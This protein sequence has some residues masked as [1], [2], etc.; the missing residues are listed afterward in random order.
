VHC[1]CGEYD[2]T[3]LTGQASEASAVERLWLMRSLATEDTASPA[4][5]VSLTRRHI[6]I[7]NNDIFSANAVFCVG[8]YYR[9]R[10]TL[11]TCVMTRLKENSAKKR[12]LAQETAQQ[13]WSAC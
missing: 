6:V 1:E 9:K 7:A 10:Q 3:D 2:A 4:S 13:M 5:V 12:R 8:M 11:T